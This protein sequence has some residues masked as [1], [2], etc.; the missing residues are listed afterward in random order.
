MEELGEGMKELKEIA[1]HKK[2]IINQP[3]APELLGTKPPT[4][5]YMVGSMA[6]ATHVVEDCHIWH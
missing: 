4:K 5:E 2:N 6:P 1:T 3:D